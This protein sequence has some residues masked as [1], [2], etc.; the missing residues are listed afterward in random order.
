MTVLGDGVFKEAIKVKQGHV[1][2]PQS[3]VTGVLI[4]RRCEYTQREDPVKT[5]G[6]DGHLVKGNQPTT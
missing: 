3:N 6:E 5:Q 1:G 2:A 4:K